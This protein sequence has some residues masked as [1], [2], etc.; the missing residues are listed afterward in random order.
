MIEHAVI[1]APAPPPP[2][3]YPATVTAADRWRRHGH[4]AAIVC[5]QSARVLFGLQRAL[6]QRGASAAVVGEL[7]PRAL[8]QD[9][10]ANGLILLSAPPACASYLDGLPYIEAASGGSPNE[11]VR[12][13]LS[14]LERRGVLAPRE[15]L[16]PGEGI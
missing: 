8:L 7:P 12:A 15:L 5:S 2:S 9:L 4:G 6:F 14:E 13:V 10:L 1:A 16:G 3:E 11:S